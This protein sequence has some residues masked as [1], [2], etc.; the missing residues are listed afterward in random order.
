MSEGRY[1]EKLTPDERR[2]EVIK[3]C[4]AQKEASRKNLVPVLIFGFG[5]LAFG[6]VFWRWV[7]GMNLV[8][9]LGLAGGL[10]L[11]TIGFNFLFTYRINSYYKILSNDFSDDDTI[12]YYYENE[13]ANQRFLSS[14]NR[15]GKYIALLSTGLVVVLSLNP[16]TIAFVIV[17]LMVGAGLF[18]LGAVIII[19]P[20]RRRWW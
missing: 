9:T 12:A 8:S 2:I 14:W 4:H 1:W 13:R 20:I 17:S 15:Y 7:F 16:K 10:L 6:L 18:L 19:S 5:A 3:V 11:A